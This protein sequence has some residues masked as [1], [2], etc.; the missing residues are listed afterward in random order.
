[1]NFPGKNTGMGCHSLLQE[2]YPIQGL[3]QSLPYCRQVLYWCHSNV[4]K[5]KEMATLSSTL[6]WK[7]HGWRSLVGYSHGRLQFTKSQ[8][9]LSNF[10]FFLSIVLFGEGN[11]NLRQ[12]SQP[13]ESRGQRGLVAY[14]LWGC[15]EPDTTKHL[16]HTHTHK[17]LQPLL[18]HSFIQAI[19]YAYNKWP[20]API[21]ACG[22]CYKY[23]GCCYKKGRYA[24]H[25]ESEIPQDILIC[26]FR[27]LQLD[28][29]GF[30]VCV[31][32]CMCVLPNA[33][34]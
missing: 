9:R 13:G 7:F 21:Y 31:C 34:K 28:K 16:T 2:I 30:H 1:M 14:R 8:T 3:N 11:G 32:A 24:F 12:C 5:E 6:A 23:C 22:R 18:I 19:T 15:R 4:C 17:C 33:I 10:T 29:L 27:L 25:Q 26:M 20:W